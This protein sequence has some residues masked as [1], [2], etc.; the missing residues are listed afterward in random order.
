MPD[1]GMGKHYWTL[2]DATKMEYYKHVWSTNVTYTSSTTLIKLA[3]L[4]QYLRLFDMQSKAARSLTRILITL[5]AMWG[6]AFFFLA[7]FSCK[8]IAKNWNFKLAGTCVAWGSKNP[9]EFFATWAAHAATNMIWD[10]LV[11]A[12][13]VPFLKG[14]RVSGKTR[15]G[16]IALF[17]MG[18]M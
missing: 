7:L 9:D 6:T 1:Y 15:A 8:P 11:L 18:G 14:L 2:D 17:T 4:F 13:P 3:I 10:I 12:L 5:V 16:L